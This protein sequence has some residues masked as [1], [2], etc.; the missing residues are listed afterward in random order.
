MV[1]PSLTLNRGFMLGW[2]L[3]LNSVWVWKC[4]LRVLWRSCPRAVRCAAS[5]VGTGVMVT[6]CPEVEL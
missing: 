3:S 5:T 4:H 1:A 6:P 2:L